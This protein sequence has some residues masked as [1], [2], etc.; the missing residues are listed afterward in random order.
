MAIR[1]AYEVIMP[2]HLH[3]PSYFLETFTEYPW[4]RPV[5]FWHPPTSKIIALST[6][7]L[8]L[9]LYYSTPIS[10]TNKKAF[11]P[12]MECQA[13]SFEVVSAIIRTYLVLTLSNEISSLRICIFVP[14]SN[15]G[16]FLEAISRKTFP[17]S[18]I[19]IFRP[20]APNMASPG[21]NNVLIKADEISFYNPQIEMFA[22][23]KMKSSFHKTKR[24]I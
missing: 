13:G 5:W 10:S 21:F 19:S 20:V 9:I 3:M 16:I 22:R 14:F 17:S 6:F 12:G 4:D 18:E 2:Y 1:M 11:F 8:L 15:T 24:I 23:F 7:C